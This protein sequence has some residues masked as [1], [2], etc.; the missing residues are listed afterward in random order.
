MVNNFEFSSI[1][2][3]VFEIFLAFVGTYVFSVIF[4]VQKKER[5]FAGIVGAAAWLGYSIFLHLGVDLA[6][7]AFVGA[8]I[9][10]ALTRVL[11]FLRY[12]PITTY[13]VPGI[14]PIV[15][16]AGIYYT[17]YYFFM[18][19]NSLGMSKALETLKIA[20][21]IALGIG[22]VLSLPKFLFDYRRKKK[23]EEIT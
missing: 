23:A 18:G 5:I 21:A 4:H 2:K 9:L 14:F 3:I 12:E 15:P 6:V 17:G 1:L 22:I 19:E 11:S 7:S 20:I 8:L 13:L 10:T 16:G